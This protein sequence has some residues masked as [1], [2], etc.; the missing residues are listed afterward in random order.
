MVESNCEALDINFIA[1]LDNEE[2]MVT[3]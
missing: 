1:E 2:E 3:P